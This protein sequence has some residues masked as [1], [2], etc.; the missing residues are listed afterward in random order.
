MTDEIITITGVWNTY[1]LKGDPAV[2]AGA[3]SVD[4]LTCNQLAFPG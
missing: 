1:S 4:I 3:T 2:S